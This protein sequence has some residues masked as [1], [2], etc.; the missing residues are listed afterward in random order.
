[1]KNT[2]WGSSQSTEVLEPG[3]VWVSTASHGGLM[4]TKTYAESHLTAAARQRGAKWGSYYTYEED[5]AYAV[6][7]WELPHLH[8]KIF[9]NH[10]KDE[11]FKNLLLKSLSTWNA[12]YLLDLGIEPEPTGYRLFLERQEDARMRKEK[13]PNLIVAAW[14]DWFTKIPGVVKVATAD[15]KEHLITSESYGQREGLNLLSKCTLYEGE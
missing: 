5:C 12:D 3:I 14:G 2:P 11:N 1:M 10:D 4:I 7:A 15:D 9:N 8:E 6:A 13:H